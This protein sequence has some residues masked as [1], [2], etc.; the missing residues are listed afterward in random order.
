MRGQTGMLV[1][2]HHPCQGGKEK[3]KS[4]SQHFGFPTLFQ[5]LE[6]LTRGPFIK[7]YAHETEENIQFP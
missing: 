1:Q 5:T 2:G 7:L 4:G 3:A 6:T